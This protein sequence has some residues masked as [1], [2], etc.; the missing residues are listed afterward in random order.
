[1]KRYAFDETPFQEQKPGVAYKVLHTEHMT[2]AAWRFD[3]GSEGA[4]HAHPQEQVAYIL[5]GKI[6]FTTDSASIVASVG[7]QVIFAANEAHASKALED[8]VILD[9]FSDVREDFRSTL[10]EMAAVDIF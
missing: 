7:D 5:K 4:K 1:M 6:E 9:I 10:S 8:S 3:K 2:V